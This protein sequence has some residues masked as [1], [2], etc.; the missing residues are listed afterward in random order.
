MVQYEAV[1]L[2]VQS[3][4]GI[5]SHIVRANLTGCR[6]RAIG[7]VERKKSSDSF[8]YARSRSGDFA[9]FSPVP[10]QSFIH[11]GELKIVTD[12]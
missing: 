2:P 7:C 8:F 4:A 11:A 10:G 9:V 5:K 6:L 3:M 12:R 1:E